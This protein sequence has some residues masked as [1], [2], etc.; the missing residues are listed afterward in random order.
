MKQER[1][2][3]INRGREDK[4]ARKENGKIITKIVI[5][6]IILSNLNVI[7]TVIKTLFTSQG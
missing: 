1:I 7:V 2:K 3:E 6:A 5:H 4:E